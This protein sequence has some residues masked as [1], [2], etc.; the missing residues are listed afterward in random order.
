MPNGQW[1]ERRAKGVLRDA[2]RQWLQV[3]IPEIDCIQ[4][5]HFER[6]LAESVYDVHCLTGKAS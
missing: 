5:P 6:R 2:V 3:R 1:G 4:E